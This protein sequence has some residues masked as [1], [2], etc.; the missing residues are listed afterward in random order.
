MSFLGLF[1]KKQKNK[2]WILQSLT[3]SISYDLQKFEVGKTTARLILLDGQIISKTFYG[4]MRQIVEK[5][6]DESLENNLWIPFRDH[7]I[8]EP[9]VITSLRMAQDLLRNLNYGELPYLDNN[10]SPT[11]FGRIIAARILKTVKYEQEFTVAKLVPR[12]EAKNP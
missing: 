5:G 10:E 4:S 2:E 7:C 6:N 3:H 12:E 9:L 1:G 11:K 8:G